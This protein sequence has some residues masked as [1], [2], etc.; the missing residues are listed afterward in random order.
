[1]THACHP[2]EASPATGSGRPRAEV[3]RFEQTI[4]FIRQTQGNQAAAELKEKLLP[5]KTENDILFKDGYC[6][7][8]TYLREKKLTR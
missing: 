3:S 5:A 6:G 2:D 8:A 4:G 1:M 7:L